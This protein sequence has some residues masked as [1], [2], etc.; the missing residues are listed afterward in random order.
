M[1]NE[2]FTQL[3]SVSTAQLTDIICAV[4]GYVNPGNPGLSVQETLAQVLALFQSNTILN[5]PGNPNGN[6]AGVQFNLCW[7]SS[8]K[9]LWVCT[10][11]GNAATAVWTISMGPLTNGQL[12]IG[13]TGNPPTASTLTAGTGINITNGAGSITISATSEGIWNNINTAGPF[14]MIVAQGYTCNNSDNP[15]ILNLPATASVGDYVEINGGSTTAWQVAQA[16][17][18]QIHVGNAITTLGA[19]GYIQ[20]TNQYDCVKLRCITANTTWTVTSMQSAGLTVN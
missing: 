4:Q 3:P 8:H 11:P 19:T 5:Y 1:P 2:M 18:Q 17:G 10:S 9:I 16:A 6:V 20:S 15:L 14:T 13:S 7:D 12:Y